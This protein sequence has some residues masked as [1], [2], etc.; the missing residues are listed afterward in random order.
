MVARIQHLI[1]TPE[2]TSST[3]HELVPAT[4]FVLACASAE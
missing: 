1:E 3:I 4:V 2:H